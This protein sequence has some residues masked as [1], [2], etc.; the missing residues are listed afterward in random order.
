[1]KTVKCTISKEFQVIL[2]TDPS[3]FPKMDKRQFASDK[4]EVLTD[5]GEL[6]YGVFLY[7]RIDA[8][9]V[10][11]SEPFKRM[12]DFKEILAF[13]PNESIK[14]TAIDSIFEKCRNILQASK[15]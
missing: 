15:E 1:M 10:F 5:K 3:T 6:L 12:Y 11:Y 2:P 14:T 4:F 13:V 8:S 9:F 7:D